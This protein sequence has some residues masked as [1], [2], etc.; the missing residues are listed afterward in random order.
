ME[1]WRIK[2]QVTRCNRSWEKEKPITKNFQLSGDPAFSIDNIRREE[3]IPLYDKIE[4]LNI[5]EA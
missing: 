2:Y 1:N 5:K 3:D 4:I